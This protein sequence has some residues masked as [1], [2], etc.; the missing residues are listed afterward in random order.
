MKHKLIYIAFLS[1]IVVL[2][3]CKKNYL[4]RNPYNSIPL[5]SS[6]STEADLTTVLNGVYGGLRTTDL[7]G[8]TLPVKGD[9]MSDNTFVTTTNS[10]R[11]LSMNNFVFNSLDAYAS[12]I[13]SNAYSVIKN[14]NNVINASIPITPNVRQYQAEALSI[15][16]L[17]LFE[18]VRNYGTPYTWDKTKDGVPI[19]LTFNYTALPARSSVQAVYTQIIKDLEAAYAMFPAKAGT[20]DS[21]FRGT[22]YFSKYSARALEARVYQHMGDWANAQITA[23]DVITNGGWSM[24]PASQYS[25]PAGS[26]SSYSPGGYWASPAVQSGTKNEAMFEVAS[27][28]L[29]NNGFDQLG[30]IY[31]TV[32]GGYGDILATPDLAALYTATDARKAL[33]PVGTRSGQAGTVYLCYK[34]P[35]PANGADKDDTKVLRISDIY[36]ILAEA[37]YNLN[38]IPNALVNVNK[39]A[40]QRDPSFTGYTSAA[41]QLLEDILTERRKELA[42]EGSRFWDLLRLGRS[43]TKI[44]NQNPLTTVA[45]TPASP[46]LILPIPQGERDANPNMSQN[47]GY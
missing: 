44:K 19:P 32:G 45:V 33:I 31:L 1:G 27:D 7:Y 40:Q 20:K 5:I 11:Y 38:D 34:Y 30:F 24:L 18:L 9:I 2:S 28:L 15:R 26:G 14:A 4:D 16:A 10:G 37:D 22:A 39:V 36:L 23:N 43:W 3:S 12:A 21:S 42:F 8:R 6:I 35:N 17:M 46:Y 25:L 47:T 13:W 29:N 41:P